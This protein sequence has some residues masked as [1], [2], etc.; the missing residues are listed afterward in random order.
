MEM[1][2]GLSFSAQLFGPLAFSGFGHRGSPILSANFTLHHWYLG[3]R[4]NRRDWP[5]PEKVRGPKSRAEKA[6]A[7]EGTQSAEEGES[8]L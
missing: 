8:A 2:L 7:T 4:K 6:R 1:F 3:A 5:K